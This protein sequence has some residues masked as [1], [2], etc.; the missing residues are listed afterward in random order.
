MTNEE[1][2]DKETDRDMALLKLAGQISA[3]KKTYKDTESLELLQTTLK[4]H[5]EI[6]FK[7][8][9]RTKR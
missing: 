9:W 5:S 8:L 3:F 6:I 1:H 2:N 4:A 7:S